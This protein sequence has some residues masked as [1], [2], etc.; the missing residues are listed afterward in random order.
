[1]IFVNRSQVRNPKGENK[2]GTAQQISNSTQIF[3]IFVNKCWIKAPK[4]IWKSV[5]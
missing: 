5:K 3:E 1:M 2:K 4:R